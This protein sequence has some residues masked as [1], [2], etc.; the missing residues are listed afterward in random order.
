MGLPAPELIACDEDN[1]GCC[2]CGPWKLGRCGLPDWEAAGGVV[3]AAREGVW[4][5][6]FSRLLDSVESPSGIKL[7][8]SVSPDVSL[9][10]AGSP[11]LES[12]PGERAADV[13]L[14][15]PSS[16]SPSSSGRLRAM[17]SGRMTA[18]RTAA[19]QRQMPLFF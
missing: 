18:A 6:L 15:A 16:A 19:P 10:S 9:G 14:S 12:G 13:R 7:M 3:E 2:V 1:D 5:P 17:S 8:I 11:S 4:L